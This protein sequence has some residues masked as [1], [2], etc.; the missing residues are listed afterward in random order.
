VSGLE[1]VSEVTLYP[2]VGA[3]VTSLPATA[4][5]PLGKRVLA[6]GFDLPTGTNLVLTQSLP[7]GSTGWKVN[8][9][10]P[11]TGLGAVSIRVWAVCVSTPTP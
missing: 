8:F 2:S 6:G 11:S 1:I 5:C 3:F 10:N 4:S 7:F 9:M